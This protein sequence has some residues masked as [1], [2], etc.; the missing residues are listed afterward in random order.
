MALDSAFIVR[1]AGACSIPSIGV[2][3]E[4]ERGAAKTEAARLLVTGRMILDLIILGVGVR[5]IVGAVTRGR[6]RRA[7]D[8]GA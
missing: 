7:Q 5:V 1:A 6:Q 3:T 4:Q 2:S 8:T